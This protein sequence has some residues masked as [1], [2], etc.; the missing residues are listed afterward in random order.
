M[1]ES[2]GDADLLIGGFLDATSVTRSTNTGAVLGTVF[3]TIPFATGAAGQLSAP[4]GVCGESAANPQLAAILL[5]LG[6]TSLSMAP[7][8]IA[9]VRGYL[10]SIDRATCVNAAMQALESLTRPCE[11]CVVTD[12]VYVSKGIAE[13]LPNWVKSLVQS[14]I[15]VPVH[16]MRRFR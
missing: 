10:A 2:V 6:V 14:E 12:S 13:W 16:M 8:A 1:G 4:I 11:V 15:K 7:V 9:E 3:G 5:G